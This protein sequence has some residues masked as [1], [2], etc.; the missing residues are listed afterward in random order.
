MSVNVWNN[1]ADMEMFTQILE[2]ISKG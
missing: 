2:K 1:E